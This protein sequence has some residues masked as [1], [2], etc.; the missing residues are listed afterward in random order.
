MRSRAAN[1]PSSAVQIDR[2]ISAPAQRTRSRPL[3]NAVRSVAG[4]VSYGALAVA[5]IAGCWGVAPFSRA[6][7]RSLLCQR[8]LHTGVALWASLMER[9]GVLRIHFPEADQLR[10]M[11]GVVIAPNHPSLL[12][13]TFFLARLPELTCLMKRAVL[14]NPFMGFSA[15]L[16]GYLSN[17][18]GPDFIRRGRDALLAGENLLIFPEGTRTVNAPVNDFKKGFALIALLAGAPVQTVFIEA[19]CFYLGKRWPLWRLPAMPVQFRVRL[20]RQ[21]R[22]GPGQTAKALGEELEA[23]FRQELEPAPEGG[24]RLATPR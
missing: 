6:R 5:V 15:R 2:L 3:L 23:Y 9:L 17:D 24:V 4:F 22:A 12:D 7:A 14:H 11:H 21:F 18:A 16:A 8:I 20:G 13:A 1:P 10:A 19:P